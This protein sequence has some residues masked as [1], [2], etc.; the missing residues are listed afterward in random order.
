MYEYGTSRAAAW[1]CP[2]T[3]MENIELFKSHPRTDDIFEVLR[4]WEDLRQKNLITQEMKEKLRNNAQEHILLIN[5]RKESEMVPYDCIKNAA[6]GNTDVSAFIFDRNGQSYVV[7]WHNTGSGYLSLPLSC[8]DVIYEA[9][10]GGE[11]L[12]IEADE[13]SVTIPLA[14]RHYLSSSL[15]KEVLKE[16]FINAILLA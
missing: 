8:K 5:E 2:I 7:C 11:K 10:I 14:G 6:N 12:A 4:R 13:N 9:E 3:M 15:P 1:D 16:A